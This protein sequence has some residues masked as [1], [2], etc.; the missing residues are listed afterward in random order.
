MI[1]KL[2][3]LLS[4]RIAYYPPSSFSLSLSLPFRSFGSHTQP[5]LSLFDSCASPCFGFSPGLN[6]PV[7]GYLFLSLSS[8]SSPLVCL[9]LPFFFAFVCLSIS[10]SCAV[11]NKA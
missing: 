6:R 9:S 4:Q 2:C 3:N 5:I 8:S 10:T 1:V 11:A 7:R